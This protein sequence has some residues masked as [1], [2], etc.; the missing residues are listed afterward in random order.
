MGYN[1]IP[2]SILISSLLIQTAFSSIQDSKLS[3][4]CTDTP[5]RN[6]TFNTNLNQVLTNLTHSAPPNYGFSTAYAS[7]G[8]YTDCVFGLALCRRDVPKDNC[9]ACLSNAK[10]NITRDC[11]TSRRAAI[12]YDYCFLKFADYSFYGQI[13]TL[14]TYTMKSDE[15][16]PHPQK[17]YNKAIGLL[18]RLSNQTG[19]AEGM[20]AKGHVSFGN[21]AIYTMAQCTRDISKDDCRTC[22]GSA[23]DKLPGISIINKT[24][25]VET[26]PLGGRSFTGS[27]FVRY[28]I[29]PFLITN[30]D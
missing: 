11:P 3:H 26:I 17:F 28:E 8:K 18:R 6:P 2:S 1:F 12:W 19:D 27:C 30:D 9:T 16:A 20:F 23:V 14:N 22:L 13:D 15:N 10:D 29:K 24:G 4:S 5:K 25:E 7:S 21:L